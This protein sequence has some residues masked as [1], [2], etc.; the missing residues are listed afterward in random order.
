MGLLDGLEE[1]LH[2]AAGA[3]GVLVQGKLAGALEELLVHQHPVLGEDLDV[4][5]LRFEVGPVILEH[6]GELV[7][8][9]LGDVGGDFLDVG[10]LLQIGAGDVER[11]VRGVDHAV[12]QRQEV[13]HDVLDVV[14]DEHLV[15]VEVDLVAL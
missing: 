4:L 13:R 14:G 15:A 7:A 3:L 9:L 12:Q 11:N 2:R 10:V 8:D 1:L 5:P 6:L